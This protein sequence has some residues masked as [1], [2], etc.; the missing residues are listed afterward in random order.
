MDASLFTRCGAGGAVLR[1]EEGRRSI[2]IFEK[3][4]AYASGRIKRLRAGLGA[5][6]IIAQQ[7]SGNFSDDIDH[8]FS[9]L[10]EKCAKNVGFDD[11]LGFWSE[12]SVRCAAIKQKQ[13]GCPFD[14]SESGLAD[15]RE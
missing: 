10:L 7:A 4:C 15:H 9:R 3:Q 6:R 8:G 11:G 14:R 5:R 2:V 12:G 13:P 1:I